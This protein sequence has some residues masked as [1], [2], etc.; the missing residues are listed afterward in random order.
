MLTRKAENRTIENAQIISKKTKIQH[1][2]NPLARTP[3]HLETKSLL[4]TIG[5]QN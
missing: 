4:A 2:L 3:T 5:Q 1:H